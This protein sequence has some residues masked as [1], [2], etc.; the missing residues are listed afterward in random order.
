MN[1]A[2]QV[3]KLAPPK[4]SSD[5]LAR[6][7]GESGVPLAETMA[8]SYLTAG[9]MN[10][11]TAGIAQKVPY[12]YSRFFPIARDAITFG[13]QS[14]L[15]PGAT[16]KSIEL[17]AGTGAI[18]G[19][20]GPYGRLA[21]IIGGVGIGAGQEY[22]TNPNATAHDYARSAMLM[23]TFAGLA[24]AE[25]AILAQSETGDFGPRY[26]EFSGKP[27][28]AIEKLIKEKQGEVPDAFTKEGIGK[29]DLVW[30]EGG[31]KGYG[32]A[33]VIERHGEDTARL[34]PKII[35]EGITENRLDRPER[36]YI[37]TPNHEAVVSLTW[38][39]V[40]KQWVLT[41]YEKF[42]SPRP[43]RTMTSGQTCGGGSAS[44]PPHG[45]TETDN[46]NDN[47]DA[48]R[49]LKCQDK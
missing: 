17:G 36:A 9:V 32:L 21:R 35:A 24:A 38:K 40:D 33:H 8:L 26:T 7:V 41:A 34:L 42:K 5:A 47:K 11:L 23:G 14:A 6:G 22:L 13:A 16:A 44:P 30:G 10:P 3:D 15:E 29:I 43:D 31:K 25:N 37:V 12:L 19:M 1:K 20:L 2:L 45:G 49:R 27:D 18:M 28:A 46:T 39:N 4:D 48:A